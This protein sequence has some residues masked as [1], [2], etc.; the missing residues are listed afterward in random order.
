MFFCKNILNKT[1][2]FY[3]FFFRIQQQAN[4]LY[5]S[6]NKL[7]N[8][9]K[10][11]L[12]ICIFFNTYY[13][14]SQVQSAK[15]KQMY[16]QRVLAT[17]KVYLFFQESSQNL[18][19]P[20]WR[21]MNMHVTEECV[22]FFPHLHSFKE[23][24]VKQNEEIIYKTDVT[25]IPELTLK[26]CEIDIIINK[27]KDTITQILKHSQFSQ[28]SAYPNHQNLM[29][30]VIE[31]R[32]KQLQN[33]L[34][35]DNQ[36]EKENKKQKQP[37]L[38]GAAIYQVKPTEE[39]VQGQK[40]I[41]NRTYIMYF[42][43]E[44]DMN[45]IYSAVKIG[46]QW[47]D[48]YYF[49]VENY[50]QPDYDFLNWIV[51]NS[52]GEGYI[53]KPFM[54]ELQYFEKNT[55]LQ[56]LQSLQVFTNGFKYIYGLQFTTQVDIQLQNY[57]FEPL[58]SMFNSQN[59]TRL[60]LSKCTLHDGILNTMFPYLYKSFNL[61]SHLDLSYNLLTDASLDFLILYIPKIQTLEVLNLSHNLFEGEERKFA[62]FIHT[63]NLLELIDNPQTVY[64]G[65]KLYM[66]HNQL[67]DSVLK[68]LE[69]FILFAKYHQF[70]YI[71]I[72]HNK[73]SCYALWRL[74]KD[75]E[76]NKYQ[77]LNN[78]SASKVVINMF[79]LPFNPSLI[80]SCVEYFYQLYVSKKKYEHYKKVKYENIQH[81]NLI[82]E[83]QELQSIQNVQDQDIQYQRKQALTIQIVRKRY[84]KNKDL[85]N[86]RKYVQKIKDISQE[87]RKIESYNLKVE[88]Y[89]VFCQSIYELEF[90]FPLQ[91]LEPLQAIIWDKLNEAILIRDHYSISIL[92]E[93]C[94]YI[95]LEVQLFQ[96]YFYRINQTIHQMNSEEQNTPN[97][98][99]NGEEIY[100]NY[101]YV[102]NDI[103]NVIQRR[104]NIQKQIEKFLN[105]DQQDETKVNYLL[106]YLVKEAV[107]LDL[108][109]NAVDFLLL[110]KEKRDIL[111]Q[112]QLAGII[113]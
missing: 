49:C 83:Q 65:F 1:N 15:Y 79:P 100:Q 109:G 62:E 69:Q 10:L 68:G 44:K 61:L 9:K 47:R 94:Y 63:I 21:Q 75:I 81:I 13:I 90:E 73:L 74:F 89:K 48:Y 29:E 4:L 105:F 107:R 5:L 111:I 6:Q 92:I 12:F 33:K 16:L 2:I 43:T 40:K 18:R 84:Q 7:Q 52:N 96:D 14:L 22:H 59:L 86:K 101:K 93:C 103:T 77:V 8:Y 57:Y 36:Q 32:K 95:G 104:E 71:D 25:L 41:F 88:E 38:I 98:E 91:K 17:K 60:S 72:S 54:V 30:K 34:Q 51:D 80:E 76:A 31:Q 11:D 97:T 56:Q 3:L 39:I 45:I 37:N 82:S 27:D 53:Q 23:N 112:R 28:D 42:E 67:K 50:M 99:Q 87:I 108:R 35:L 46:K 113:Q 55:S 70:F 78:Q 106:D 85:P 26:L 64:D 24:E 102:Q 110:I 58:E 66:S 19:A 20:T